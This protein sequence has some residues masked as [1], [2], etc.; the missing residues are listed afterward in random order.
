MW[1]P[2]SNFEKGSGVPALNFDGGGGPSVP[3]LNLS[4]VP[5]LTLKLECGPR[6][7]APGS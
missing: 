3:L 7:R 1:A 5:G 2:L 4:V 6:S